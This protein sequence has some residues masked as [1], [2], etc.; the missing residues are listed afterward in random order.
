MNEVIVQP[1]HAS[2]LQRHRCHPTQN[3]Y[4]APA[5]NALYAGLLALSIVLI[6]LLIGGTRLVFSLPAYAILVAAAI[7]SLPA[8]GRKPARANIPCLAISAAFFGYILYQAAHSPWDYLW[9]MDFYQV[10]ACLMV[11]LLTTTVI[12]DVRSR[13]WVVIALLAL[14]V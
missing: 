2:T 10:I 12:T 6:E 7:L 9:W 13:I 3:R 1:F 14:A 11:Y 4:S 8:L 5:L